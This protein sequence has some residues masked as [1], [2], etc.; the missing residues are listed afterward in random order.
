[1]TSVAEQARMP[2][3]RPGTRWRVYGPTIVGGMRVWKVFDVTVFPWVQV[4]P[5]CLSREAAVERAGEL[6]GGRKVVWFGNTRL[7]PRAL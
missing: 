1:M 5:P 2:R 7:E 6:A 3:P 4:G